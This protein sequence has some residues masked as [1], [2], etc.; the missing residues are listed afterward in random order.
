M[1]I[2]IYP[3]DVSSTGKYKAEDL[4]V[5]RDYPASELARS[6]W[7]L[8]KA[9]E[10][11]AVFELMYHGNHRKAA[12]LV[13]ELIKQHPEL[14]EEIRKDYI[15]ELRTYLFEYELDKIPSCPD[16]FPDPTKIIYVC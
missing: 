3:W 4:K 8:G 5:I 1:E 6:V 11:A 16:E 12:M 9:A 7:V 10:Q 14:E 15:G 2:R 13:R